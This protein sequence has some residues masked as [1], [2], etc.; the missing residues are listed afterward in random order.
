MYFIIC[1][2]QNIFNSRHLL[3]FYNH[4]SDLAGFVKAFLIVKVLNTRQSNTGMQSSKF[5]FIMCN[6]KV[7]AKLVFQNGCLYDNPRPG[8]VLDISILKIDF[9]KLIRHHIQ[10]FTI[11]KNCVQ[12][13]LSPLPVYSTY[14]HQIDK[15]SSSNT[16]IEA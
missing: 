15:A 4:K 13:R 16:L 11:S 10:T 2:N 8:I 14:Y 9:T 12:L 1:S 3:N 6:T 5:V 7:K